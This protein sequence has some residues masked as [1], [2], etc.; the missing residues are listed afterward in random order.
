MSAIVDKEKCTAC[1]T[2]VEVCPAGAISLNLF[3]KFYRSGRPRNVA[4]FIIYHKG[5][6]TDKV[7]QSNYRVRIRYSLIFSGLLKAVGE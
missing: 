4:P 5:F 2:C 1:G 3:D 7:I 6:F